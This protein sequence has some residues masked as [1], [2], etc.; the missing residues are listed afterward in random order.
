MREISSILDTNLGNKMKIIY[1]NS[2]HDGGQYIEESI[3][4]AKSFRKYL[5]NAFIEIYTNTSNSLDSVFDRVHVLDFVVP[6]LLKNRIH[7]RGQMLVKMQAMLETNHDHNLYLG[8]DTHALNKK[9]AEPFNLLNRY[10]FALVHAPYQHEMKTEVPSCFREWNC[11]VIYWRKN[12]VTQNFIAEWKRL[13]ENDIIDHAH[14]QG[15]FRHLAWQMQNVNIFTL[16][17]QYN[18]RCGLFGSQ[19]GVGT[20]ISDSVI[21][22]N[23]GIIKKLQN[24]TTRHNK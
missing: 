3:L 16:P 6:D 7:K 4:S 20:D 10:D 19:G 24:D 8:C 17:Y 22:Q 15:S 18:N 23:R 9:V 14:D 12:H 21:I 13:Y 11:D 2:D 5:P 1:V